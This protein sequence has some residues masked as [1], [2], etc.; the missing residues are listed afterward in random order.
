MQ[1]MAKQERRNVSL[2][3]NP[4][5]FP[6]FTVSCLEK[7][8]KHEKPRTNSQKPMK[9]AHPNICPDSVLLIFLYAVFGTSFSGLKHQTHNASPVTSL[10]LSS[11]LKGM[12]RGV[13]E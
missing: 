7:V 4:R 11:M 13:V 3:H 12:C 10:Y 2:E 8:S 6:D 1:K 5:V 9:D